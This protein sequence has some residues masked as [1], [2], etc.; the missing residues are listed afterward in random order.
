MTSAGLISTKYKVLRDKQEKNN[1]WT[2]PPSDYCE[3]TEVVHLKTGDY[4]VQGHESEIIIE[5]KGRLSEF[6]GNVS[7][8]RFWNELERMEA[9]PRAY[10]ICEFEYKDILMWPFGCGL[11][12]NVLKRIR[13]T[14][15]FILKCITRI[16]MDYKTKVMLVGKQG[17]MLASLMFKK[18]MDDNG[19]KKEEG[20]AAF[21]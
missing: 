11:P 9:F 20:P 8:D 19:A 14:K 16:Q 17:Q 2:F 3:G 1:F 10:L 7:E 21:I 5:R 15:N 12:P 13:V 4:T 18:L 6:A